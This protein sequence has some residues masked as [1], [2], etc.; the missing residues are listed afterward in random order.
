MESHNRNFLNKALQTAQDRI[1][2]ST[3]QTTVPTSSRLWQ[4][5]PDRYISTAL[6]WL[7]NRI[8]RDRENW[9]KRPETHSH[10]HFSSYRF[11][12]D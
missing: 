10:P 12:I 9:R 8:V 3:P 11:A 7:I 2:M 1:H 6:K 5:G 4:S